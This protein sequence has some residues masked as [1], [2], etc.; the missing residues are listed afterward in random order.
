[1]STITIFGAGNIGG[2]VA[3]IAVAGGNTVQ[4]IDSTLDKAQEVAGPLG[5]TA[6]TTGD[7]IRGDIV[8]LALPY[9]AI[10]AVLETYAGQLD[11]KIVVETTNPLDFS[12]FDSLLTPADGSTTAEIQA[13]L[14]S[15]SVLKAFNTTFAGTLAA[16]TVGGNATTVLV[17]GDSADAKASVIDV[18]VAGG[19]NA[20]DAGSLKRAREL[21]AIGFLQLT[22]AAQE[23]ISWVGGFAVVK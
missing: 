21:E 11:G 1:M 13:K 19:L 17:A 6:S 8:V 3:G 12:T 18:I 10:D 15:A 7:P 9:A 4:L 2:A 14:P 22:L 20:I 5:A 23:K 16:K